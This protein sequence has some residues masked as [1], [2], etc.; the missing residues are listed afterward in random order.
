MPTR[1]QCARCSTDCAWRR[2][3]A[4]TRSPRWQRPLRCIKPWRSKWAASS[5]PL[6]WVL[7]RGPTLRKEL[8]MDWK[9]LAGILV[10]AIGACFV[11]MTGTARKDPPLWMLISRTLKWRLPVLARALVGATLAAAAIKGWDQSQDT[12]FFVAVLLFAVA[13]VLLALPFYQ[14][15]AATRR[16]RTQCLRKKMARRRPQALASCSADD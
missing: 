13:Q 4:P 3:A 7:S 5:R 2:T 10:P 14:H 8:R 16:A 1:R 9:F 15:S 6:K 12:I 11:W